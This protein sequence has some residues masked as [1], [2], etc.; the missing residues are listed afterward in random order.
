MFISNGI[1]YGEGHESPVR[2]HS[3]RAL[4][5]MIMMITFSS[6]EQRL[7]DA[8]ILKGPVF[9]P[10]KDPEI[11][12]NVSVEY[13]VATWMDGE[14]DCAPEYMYQHSYKYPGGPVLSAGEQIGEAAGCRRQLEL[15][16]GQAGK[17]PVSKDGESEKRA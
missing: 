4:D 2:I 11:F 3:V 1:V 8:A 10:L 13:G 5:D 7:F 15:E 16:A 9:E 12:Q 6:G 17:L 14:I